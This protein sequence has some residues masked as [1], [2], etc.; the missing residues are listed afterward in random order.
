MAGL[1]IWDCGAQMQ[2]AGHSQQATHGWVYSVGLNC[3]QLRTDP[4]DS[5]SF[6]LFV[7]NHHSTSTAI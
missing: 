3:G 1:G 4:P 5:F 6:F 7:A 2:T